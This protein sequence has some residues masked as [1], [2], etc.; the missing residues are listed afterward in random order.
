MERMAFGELISSTAPKTLKQGVARRPIS[1]IFKT[2]S[3]SAGN[4]WL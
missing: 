2:W 4:K 1:R 3:Q